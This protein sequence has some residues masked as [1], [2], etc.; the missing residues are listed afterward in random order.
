M[1]RRLGLL[2]RRV[3]GKS[4]QD[5]GQRG[6]VLHMELYTIH[7]ERLAV[8][9]TKLC[10]VVDS[11]GLTLR[12]PIGRAV[13]LAISSP[14]RLSQLHAVCDAERFALFFTLVIA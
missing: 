6:S 13:S 1:C 9:G 14:I 3:A 8:H 10:A 11:I 12:C 4:P 7:S 2:Q 5:A